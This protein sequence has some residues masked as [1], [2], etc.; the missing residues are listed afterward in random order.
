MWA[1]SLA[2]KRSVNEVLRPCLAMLLSTQTLVRWL[3][4]IIIQID[5]YRI[6]STIHGRK[7]DVV[8]QALTQDVESTSTSEETA[9]ISGHCPL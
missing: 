7:T 3:S 8:V 2:H 1:S 6:G 4:T 9:V 5:S